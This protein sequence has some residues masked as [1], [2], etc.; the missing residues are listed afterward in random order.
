MQAA[1]ANHAEQTVALKATRD[2]IAA[3]RAETRR[4]D[5]LHRTLLENT[6]IAGQAAKVQTDLMQTQRAVDRQQ[7]EVTK[8]EAAS[9]L[10]SARAT[11]LRARAD[12]L[13]AE[14]LHDQADEVNSEIADLSTQK[15]NV[16]A[17]VARACACLLAL[18]KD[19]TLAAEHA[20][21]VQ[22]EVSMRSDIKDLLCNLHASEVQAAQQTS[23][24]DAALAVAVHAEALVA[25]KA[26]E[27]AAMEAAANKAQR[28]V[29]ELKAS[30]QA[31]ES[32][33]ALAE[34]MKI[35]KAAARISAEAAQA[36]SEAAA[37]RSTAATMQAAVKNTAATMQQTRTRIDHLSTTAK[38]MTAAREYDHA[39]AVAAQEALAA[40]QA[41]AVKKKELLNADGALTKCKAEMEAQ[42]QTVSA[43]QSESD[44]AQERL[45][46]ATKVRNY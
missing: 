25:E 46:L 26:A 6:E 38:T 19:A 41:A 34:A 42:L 33:K 8:Y 22:H 31:V 37:K 24:A 2:D 29:A 1:E 11:Q 14:G 13:K 4:A 21:T 23:A 7:R 9:A 43:A 39:T 32:T 10:T 36:R 40:Q 28:K 35:S 3:L 18:R 12:R 5:E 20:S 16:A 27:A 15:Y 30:G 45:R 17:T 44:A